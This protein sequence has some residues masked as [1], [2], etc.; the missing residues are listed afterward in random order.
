MMFYRA[1]IVAPGALLTGAAFVGLDLGGS[2]LASAAIAAEYSDRTVG[3]GTPLETQLQSVV[4]QVYIGLMGAPA[5]ETS[6]A[7]RYVAPEAASELEQLWARVAERGIRSVQVGTPEQIS[8]G[9]Y[10]FEVRE[11]AAGAAHP[12]QVGSST[13]TVG[14]RQWLL[15]DGVGSDWAVVAIAVGSAPE[16]Q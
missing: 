5:P 14:Q 9:V 10:R 13:F 16:E 8:P 4:D 3:G 6:T 15:E 1:A 12:E 11:L 7:A 2:W